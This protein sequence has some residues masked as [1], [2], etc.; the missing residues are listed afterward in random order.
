MVL[1]PETDSTTGLLRLVGDNTPEDIRFFPG[2]LGVFKLGAFL[3]GGDDTVRGSSDPELIYGDS[4]NDQLFG[5]GGND[6]LFGGVGDD[7]ILG[8]EGNDLL[9]GEAGN[10]RFVGFVNPDNP[11]QL[12]GV[13]GDDTIYS[14]SGNDQVR[15]DLGKD[16]IFGGQGN[17][18]LRAGADNDWV[19][20]NDGDDFIGG[21]DGDDTVFGGNGNDQIRGDGGNDLVTGN[22]GDDQVSGGIGNDTLVGGQGN[23]QI[24]GDNGNDWISGDA[25][26][27]TL[28]GG[29]GKDIFVLDSNNLELS[30]IIVDYKPEE[31]IIFLTGDLAFKNLTIKSDPRNENSTIISSNL[32]EIV[33]ILQGIKP[34]QIN[35]SNFII[36]GSVAFSSEQFAVNENGTIINPITVVR[37]SGN[38]GE[39]SVTVVPIPTPLTP[40]GNQVDTT[41]I[42]VN[43]A[44]GD[45]TPKIIKI[46][47]VNN[48]F[49]N[50]SS[51]LLLTLENPTNFA[52]I[53]TPNQAILDII[54]DEIPPSALGKLVNPIPETN[55]QFGSNLSRLGNNFLAIAAPG[56]TNNQ[57]IAYLF[58]LTTQQPTLTFR[59]PSA[60]AG[61][62][63]FGQ[64]VATTLGDNIIIGASQDSSLAPNSGAVYGFNTATGA[65][66]LTINNPTP[67]IF[68]LFG[69]SVATLGNNI[70]VGAPGNSTLAPTGGIAYLLDE[71][72]GQLL[73][74]FLNSNPQV[75][76]FFGAS[77][78]AVGGDRILIG[79]PASLTPTGGKQPGEAYM[80][81]SVTGQLL[82]TFK[83]P[84]PGLD[85]FGYSVAWTG[86]GRDILIGAP[87]NDQGGI[88]A[89]IAFLFDGITGA[90]LQRYNAPKVEEFNQFGQA[91][92]LIGNEVLI[93]SPGY[94]LGNLG[95]TF[96]YELR[97]GNLVQ[98]YLSPVTDNSDTDLNFGTSVASVGN[99]VLVGVPNLD[100]TLPSAGAVVQFV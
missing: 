73:Q 21:E 5:E 48:N 67:N 89:G 7:Q 20:G 75:N 43:F 54:D 39:I 1:K 13:E 4:D 93:G 60:T 38:D 16:F 58:N 90:V 98:T 33:A 66:Y 47:I 78:A 27:D 65:P 12:S 97:S 31:D 86:V 52:Q 72:T 49:P 46:P 23:D 6:T 18:E 64:S 77:V 35:R 85:N 87:G 28:I 8:G 30:D 32:G 61:T 42:I 55:A 26:S 81:D 56:Q 71:N 59:N 84:N 40:T 62:S 70:I 83:N 22:A 94:G 95:G 74:T 92:A 99:L 2:E 36:P 69:Y 88:D 11:T 80:F 53:G 96:R 24:I 68:D 57:G 19:E 44:N 41:P 50:Y 34:D 100:I 17:D 37:N 91:L 3:L 82:Q 45:T 79:A 15:E 29:E 51:N 25:G 9:F 63:K 76:D 14:G 10:D